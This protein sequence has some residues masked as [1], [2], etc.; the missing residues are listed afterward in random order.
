MD[1]SSEVLRRFDSPATAGETDG[2]DADAGL[3]AGEAED[4]SLNVWVRFQVQL[5]DGA[6][7]DVRFRAFG[8]PHTIAAADWAAERLHGRPAAALRQI[9]V[10]RIRR[11]LE[12]PT[13]K[14]GKLLRI[15]DALAACADRIG[16][17]APED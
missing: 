16:V 9:D 14:L 17:P 2:A 6:I 12:I 13:E 10:P 7:R 3:V 1:Y 11:E 8:C 5:R 15:E 4:R